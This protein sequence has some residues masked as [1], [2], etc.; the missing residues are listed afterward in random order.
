MRTDVTSGRLTS[1]ISYRL[2]VEGIVDV[3]IYMLELDG[4]VATWNQAAQRIKG[5]TAKE[6]I[7][8]HFSRFYSAGD[9]S[10]GV[11]EQNLHIAR[12]LG[13]FEGEGWRIRKDGSR[14]WASVAVDALRD[15]AGELFGFAK[16]TR[17]ITD[18]S[19]AEEQRQ[20]I[21]NAAPNGMLIIDEAGT[22]TL[23][24]AQ[25][26]RIFGYRPGSLVGLSVDRLLIG[27]AIDWPVY[28]NALPALDRGL[29]LSQF[30][31]REELTGRR[32]D[33]TAFAAEVTF[34]ATPTARGPVVVASVTDISERRA[35]EEERRRFET[36]LISANRLMTMAEDIAHYGHWRIDLRSKEIYWSDEVYRVF[37]YPRSFVPTLENAIAASDPDGADIGQIIRK[38]SVDGEPFTYETRRLRPDGRM[39]DV[40]VAGRG[41]RDE[42]GTL[43]GLVGILQDVTESKDAERERNALIERVTLATQTGK[44]GIWDWNIAS[45]AVTWDAHMFSLFG[46]EQSAPLLLEQWV[47]ALHEHDRDRTLREIEDALAGRKP[48]DTQFQIVWPSGEIRTIRA[49]G[50]VLR[51]TTDQP[52]R[53]VGINWDITEARSL[54]DQLHEDKERRRA[55]ERE[56]LYE[57]ERKWSTTFQRAVLPLALP[58]VAGCTFDAVYEPGLG[59]AQV[60]G[61]WY[62]AVHL[63]DG[64]VLVSIGDVAGS[65]LEAAVVVGV[66]RQIMRG[67]AQLHANPMLV[68]DAADR[69]LCLEYPG[70]YVSA[71]VGLI[72]L[73]TRTITYASA[74][75]PAPLVVSRDGSV[76]ELADPT[77]MLIGLR[78]GHR[79]TPGTV[80]IAQ[81][82]TLVLY[83]DGVTEAYH[84]LIA[85]G[86][87]V[88]DA[89]ATLATAP[90]RHPADTIKQHVIPSGSFDDVAILVVRTDLR[91]AER[92]IDRWRF[93]VSDGAAAGKVRGEFLESLE[94]HRFTSNQC[95]NAELVFGELIGNVVRHARSASGV[96]VVLDHGGPYS[97]L[98][99]LDRGSGFH[100]ISRLPPD[101]YA[102][103][104]RGLF[105]IAALTVDFTVAE[106]PDGGSHARVVLRG[107]A[108]A[109]R[110]PALLRTSAVS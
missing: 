104:G 9:R 78:E 95:A 107:G 21:V 24:N 61:D 18:R 105:L 34:N 85:G 69:A 17:D 90:G 28:R 3:A 22:I 100:H 12:T 88:R 87:A 76:R 101:P 20:V 45:G 79:G 67:I 36:A 70:V 84:D 35:A 83:T 65:G 48:F 47:D 81:G 2:L 110:R 25:A 42:D 58:R 109:G 92:H 11:P 89:A 16:V 93:D 80:G 44:L 60:G 49:Q 64:R 97:V 59:D 51:D 39:C 19:I 52:V 50:T 106:R 77:T 98:H 31:A 86:Q 75:H 63:M 99:V 6:I 55:H 8:Q 27:D 108:K 103:S 82:D 38:A 7:G 56:R 66:V 29:R 74:G 23:A 5:Y 46:R 26:E 43:I 94:Q 14:F 40:R 13:K 10:R 1:E 73:V 41:E 15:P 96:D 53:M 4:T 71:W 54:A 30:C 102:E 68:L 57:H 72:D 33:G 91:E 37:G 32:R 62:D